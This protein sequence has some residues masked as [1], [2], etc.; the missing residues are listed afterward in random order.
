MNFKK[1][2]QNFCIFRQIEFI[3]QLR[4]QATEHNKGIRHIIPFTIL[5]PIS[6]FQF[7]SFISYS[8]LFFPP[9]GLLIL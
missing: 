7:V 1:N 9:F 5:I 6:F 8:L 3:D 4:K 2:Y